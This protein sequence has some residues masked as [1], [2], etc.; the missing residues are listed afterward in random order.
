MHT[1]QPSTGIVVLNWNGGADTLAC[2][3]SIRA[4]TISVYVI[5]VDNGSSDGSAEQIHA[6]G[7]ADDV[8]TNGENLGYAEG[9]NVGLRVALRSGFETIIV[10]NNDTVV[11]PDALEL[12]CDALAPSELRAVSPNIG[13]F[14]ASSGRWFAGGIVD[15]GWPRHLQPAEIVESSAPLRRSEC[16]TGCCIGARRET[17]NKV[18]LFDPAY[19]LI[20][21]DSDWS[22][23]AVSA[24]V[25]L[26]V[27]SKSEIHHR[28]SRSFQDRPTWLLGSFY[29]V[30]NGLRF[31]ARYFA[32]YLLLF[33]FQWLIRPAPSFVRAGRGSEV[34]FRYLGAL[35]FAMG[36]S[37]RAPDT[38]QRLAERLTR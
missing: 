4:S 28:V 13:Y 14:D 21:E 23:R 18:G 36:Q 22:M 1:S 6:S 2:L 10:L 19:F 7:L 38:V 12:L 29:A 9:N 25:A 26:Y 24:G 20:F 11:E 8:I 16:L 15:R 3:K 5:V 17:W 30:R 27:V 37:G 33:V 32:R 34:A 31:E 35:A